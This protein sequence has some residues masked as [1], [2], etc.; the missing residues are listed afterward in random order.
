MQWDSFSSGQIGSKIW[1]GDKLAECVRLN[2]IKAPLSGHRIEILAGWYAVTNLLLRTQNKLPIEFVR[3]WD[4]DPS[5][6]PIAV[7]VN[8][9]WHW[10]GQFT[11]VTHDVNKIDWW[12]VGQQPSII[13]NTSVEHIE[14]REWFDR[15]P[16]GTIVVLQGNNMPHDDHVASYDTADDF[17]AA[18]PL[19]DTLYV[20]SKL[21]Q[22]PEWQ[23]HRH[24]IIGQK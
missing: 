17:A 8:R 20:G 15:I 23:F 24:M 3:S 18:W 6:E 7:N 11:A 5:C 21:F 4:Q 13:I 19:A 10:Q 1:L 12:A 14:S 9:L 22:Y 2:D 16:D